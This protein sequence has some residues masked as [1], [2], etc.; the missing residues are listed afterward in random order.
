MRPF[1]NSPIVTRLQKAHGVV[2]G[3]SRLHELS[4]GGSTIAPGYH[5]TLNPY[6]NLAHSGGRPPAAWPA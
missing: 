5:T 3:K 6:L 4:F 2:L 1:N